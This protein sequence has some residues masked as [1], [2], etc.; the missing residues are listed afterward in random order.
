MKHIDTLKGNSPEDHRVEE[1][2]EGPNVDMVAILFF[3]KNFRSHVI[4]GAA[5]SIYF[6]LGFPGKSQVTNFGDNLILLALAQDILRLDIPVK[7]V[8]GV[9]EL[10]TIDYIAYYFYA[11]VE[12]KH[13][14]IFDTLQH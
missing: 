9:H 10:E 7:D 2:A 11:L 5:K 3:F 8:F 4:G 14:I 1:D 6:F 13:S 12:G